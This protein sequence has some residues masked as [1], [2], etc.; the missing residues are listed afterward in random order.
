ME[1]YENLIKPLDQKAMEIA[2]KYKNTHVSPKKLG[3]TGGY[4]CSNY[5]N[6]WQG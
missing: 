6:Y 5:G 4:F 3:K 1:K 2:G